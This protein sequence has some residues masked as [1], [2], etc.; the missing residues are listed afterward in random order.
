MFDLRLTGH[1]NILGQ[2]WFYCYTYFLTSTKY[3]K[4]GLTCLSEYRLRKE[5][6][7]WHLRGLCTSPPLTK[8]T[9]NALRPGRRPFGSCACDT[10]LPE[11]AP[12][13]TRR[14]HFTITGL[15][16]RNL[17][18]IALF[19]LGRP[20]RF[21]CCPVTHYPRR[22]SCCTFADN[23]PAVLPSPSCGRALHRCA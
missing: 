14:K 11:A 13:A 9:S 4:L 20:G 8:G 22:R 5:T 12:P 19:C 15:F 7:V 6:G 23:S 17:D 1:N 3:G 10:A 2:K 21:A 16:G 18:S